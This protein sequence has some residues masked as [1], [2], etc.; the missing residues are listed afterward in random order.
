VDISVPCDE[1]YLWQVRAID[2][3]WNAGAWSEERVF[4]VVD[5]TKPPAP[6][7]LEPQDGAEI[8]C[9][10]DPT[11]ANLR[12][13]EVK[14]PSGIVGYLIQLEAV[15]YTTPMGPTPA[16]I[17]IGPVKGTAFEILLNC[18]RDY[19]WRVQAVDGA[20]NTGAWSEER[21]FSVI[22]KTGPPAPTLLE[23]QDGAE[24]PS[25]TGQSA[26]V[27]LRWSQVTAPSGIARYD[28]ELVK[29]P[30]YPPLPITSTL[31]IE[32]S[33]PQ[34]II[35]SGC[36][37]SYDWR[38]RAVDSAGNVG[39][40]SGS[41]HFR[42]LTLQETDQT[43][44]QAPTPLEPGSPYES[45]PTVLESCGQVV[46]RW[47]AASDDPNGSGIQDYRV[48]LQQYDDGT[49]AGIEPYSPIY[50]TSIDVAEWLSIGRYRWS[51]W[52]RDKAGNQ[53]DA[54][55]WLYFECPDQISP[56]IPTPLK[57]GRTDYTDPEKDVKCPVTLIWDPVSDPSGVVYE[58]ILE[59]RD[60]LSEG[61]KWAGRWYPV[62]G[63]N[64]EVSY[65]Q[66]KEETEYRW[67][68]RAQDGAWNWSGWS[69]WLY[70]VT[71]PD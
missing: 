32:G 57:P 6:K 48:N 31:Q 59:R 13:S 3:A 7:L 38:V 53:G 68:V 63:S 37:N 39:E 26:S 66:C 70:Y 67:R 40:W 44:P 36:G 24:I 71:H 19:R 12:W 27:T 56:Q 8:P 11:T 61:W 64:L 46:L 41:W 28:V 49:W 50:E 20:G 30:D 4:S 29:R 15:V 55:A 25:P 52:A 9:P 21:V 34:T 18:G 65:P 45:K 17:Y 23:P 47:E 54:S 14:D 62:L 33:Q 60:E 16:P 2:K 1:T 5:T 43:P 58:V 69:K 42:V 10:A 22:D 35:S 51:V